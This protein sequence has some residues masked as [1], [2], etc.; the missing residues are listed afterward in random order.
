MRH[1]AV[2]SSCAEGRRMISR[3]S[4]VIATLLVAFAAAGGE[5]RAQYYYVYPAWRAYPPL[6]PGY[7]PLPRVQADEDFEPV[8]PYVR[9]PD[10]AWVPRPNVPQGRAA[11][12]AEANAAPSGAGVDPRYA[13]L[14]PEDRPET[15]PRKELPSQFRRT[16]VEYPTR[17]PAGT[18]IIDTPNTY[19]YL[20]LG[21]GKAM[22]YG[23][24]VG[25]E[26]FTW[27]GV[28]RV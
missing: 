23:I 13:A 24:G 26:G 19:L 18:I 2:L 9:A 14:P 4:A 15:G 22:R 3:N 6:P 27:S 1:V 5:A 28:E 17:E 7:R 11:A 16:Q 25:R 20:V 10:G 12:P 21:N 8:S